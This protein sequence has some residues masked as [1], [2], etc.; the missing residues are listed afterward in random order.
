MSEAKKLLELTEEQ[1]ER[2]RRLETE[3]SFDKLTASFSIE[4][5]DAANRRKQVFYSASVSRK[6]PEGWTP[7]EVQVASC[8]L[9]KHVVTT[10]YRDALRRR[11]LTR[12]VVVAELAGILSAY[13][14]NIARLMS[15]GTENEAP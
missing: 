13:D 3:I 15:G 12:D 4:D 8:L 14:Q 9:S 5:R 11:V 2:L 7:Q 6:G 1:K 10:T